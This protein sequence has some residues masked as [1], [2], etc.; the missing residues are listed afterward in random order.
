MILARTLSLAAF[1]LA[2]AFGAPAGADITVFAAAS[3]KTALDEV[4]AGWQAQGGERVVLVYG[5][6]SALAR[7]IEAG[8]PASAFISAS[9]EW[10]DY[11]DERSLLAEGSRRDLLGNALVLVAP[12]EGSAEA[13][14]VAPDT[15]LA[16]ML[17]GGV[18]AMAMVD[19]VP[20]GV[21]GKQSLSALNLW[22]KVSGQVAQTEDVR[23]A[24]ALVARGE[25]ALG[26]VYATDAAA[27]P[28]VHVAARF[29]EDSH[30]PIT[31]PAARIE[32]ADTDATAFLDYLSTDPARAIFA[33]QGFT[34][35]D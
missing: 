31:Y 5:G 24:L 16:A 11:L 22:D 35:K 6:S 20:A 29:P 1:G 25:A 18:L 14:T 17:D 27:E 26:V 28:R 32:D 23:A 15:D 30:D 21:Y 2:L 13:V 9:V 10:M 8:G 34:L 33:A 7:Q 4:A 12:G 3:L 19:S